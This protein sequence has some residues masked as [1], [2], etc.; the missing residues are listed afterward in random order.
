M[1]SRM[2]KLVSAAVILIVAGLVITL[3]D[4][5][6]APAYGLG[7]TVQAT[8]DMRYIHTKYFDSS[9]DGLAKECWLEFD[10]TGQAR[11]VRINWSPPFPKDVVVV[12]NEHETK[13]WRPA[14]NLLTVFNDHIYTSRTYNMWEA[15]SPRL[16]VERLY[17]RQK[18]GE[19]EIEVDE[20]SD[21]SE[22]IIVTATCLAES[23]SYGD[24]RVLSVNRATKLVTACELYQLKDG[25]YAYRGV[26]EYH[27]YDLPIDA[28]IFD[29]DDEVSAD[30]TRVDTRIQDIGLAQGDLTDEETAVKLVRQFIESLIVKD[31]TRAGQF[32]EGL[33]Q[34]EIKKGWGKLNII[35]LVSVGEPGPPS[36]PSKLFPKMLSVPYA[37]EVEK[38]G[39]K[40]TL[41][42]QVNA[43]RALGRRE[44]WVV[45]Y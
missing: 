35:R 11:N 13:I 21:K 28:T 41:E 3:V 24:R 25:E 39:E 10:E 7:Q 38:D 14:K 17:E 40:T 12:W 32:V 2:T 6:V 22:P 5:W 44:R 20:P 9:H 42:S 31:Y 18:K 1:R 19:V 16:M 45:Y 30:A 8:H 23:P 37:I 15:E 36:K 27:D 29:L 34:D 4:K 33:P 26:W 43:R